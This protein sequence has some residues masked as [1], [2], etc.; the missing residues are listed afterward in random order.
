MRRAAQTLRQVAAL[1]ALALVATACTGNGEP[2]TT[3][4]AVFPTTNNLFVGSEVRVMGLQVGEV[5][6]IEPRGEVVEVALR[7]DGY[8]VPE[9]VRAHLEPTSLLG[10]R[11]VQLSPAYTGGPTFPDGGVLGLDRTAVP[12]DIDDV[13]RSFENFLRSLDRDVL[14]TL[15]DTLADTFAGQGEGLNQLLDQGSESVR[16]LADSSAD[17]NALVGSSPS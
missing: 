15:I 2:S 6:S 7:V 3:L 13:L 12:V 4:T 9:D 14:A 5:L 16:V 10:E 1:L 8:D 17:L 11:F